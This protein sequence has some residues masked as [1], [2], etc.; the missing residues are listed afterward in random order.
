ML[1][2][3]ILRCGSILPITVL[4]LFSLAGGC[5]S[6]PA[7]APR[8]APN[9]PQASKASAVAEAASVPEPQPIAELEAQPVVE[10]NATAPERYVVVQGDT[11]WGIA[12]KFLK[13]PW[14]WP[15]I[16]HVNPQ[17]DNPHLIYPGDVLTLVYI[18]GRPYIQVGDGPRIAGAHAIKLSPQ[19]RVEA[20]ARG[21]NRVPVQAIQ[22]FITR[23]RVVSKE[24]LDSAPYILSAH[25][26]RLIYGSG[27]RVY[28]RGTEVL[29][30]GDRY[31]VFRRGQVLVDPVTNE[32]LGYEAILIA[33]ATVIKS[34]DPSTVALENNQREALKGDR[35]LPLNEEQDRIF[36]PRAPQQEINGIIISLFDA[37]SQI[38]QHQVA[39]LNVGTRNSVE[40]GHVLTVYQAGRTVHD[41]FAT[42]EQSES[43]VLPAEKT[44]LIMVFRTFEKV[45]Y[46]LVMDA[47]RPIHIGDTVQPPE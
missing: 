15:E 34:G 1:A 5:A 21:R 36:F 16:W 18:N 45:S 35:L 11:L 13:D 27:D 43:V 41:P 40:K 2:S 10:L 29:N 23:P 6:N 3:M 20:L 26:D 39:V 30:K 7:S 14:Y 44:G 24:Q 37:I 47:T 33:D 28:V 8:P 31:S 19:V 4:A 12:S 17:V 42:V 32:S 46:A 38:G 9:T 22:Q 25:D